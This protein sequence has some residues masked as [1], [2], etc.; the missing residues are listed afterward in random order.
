MTR[1]PVAANGV[2]AFFCVKN[3]TGSCILHKRSSSLGVLA[4]LA[5]EEGSRPFIGSLVLPFV[6]RKD[7]PRPPAQVQ[8]VGSSQSEDE[9][10][11]NYVPRL[12]LHQFYC[13]CE[14]HSDSPLLQG[15]ALF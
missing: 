15:V 3:G 4:V 6:Q 14:R 8:A 7:R 9:S 13:A 1:A 11:R 12:N 5:G 2:F 10:F